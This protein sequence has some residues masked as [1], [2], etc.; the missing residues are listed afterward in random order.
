[1][2][3]DNGIYILQAKDGFRVKEAMAIENLWWWWD[4]ERLYDEKFVKREEKRLKKLYDQGKTKILN[5]F[6][7]KGGARD[8]I[9]PRM[10]KQIFGCCEVLKT[11]EESMNKAGEIYQ[12]IMESEFPICEY[13][14]QIIRE[15]KDNDFP[16]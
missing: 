7:G 4:D 16:T 1:M 14:I 6:Y 2:S 3:A 12:Q 10:L 5:P 8:T 13:G 9:N 15:W 11:E